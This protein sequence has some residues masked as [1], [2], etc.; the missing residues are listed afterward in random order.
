MMASWQVVGK[1]LPFVY[2]F[3]IQVDFKNN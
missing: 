1:N 2:N 3:P